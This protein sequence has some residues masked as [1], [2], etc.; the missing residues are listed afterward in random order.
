[1]HAR[2]LHR[3]SECTSGRFPLFLASRRPLSR[4]FVRAYTCA[5]IIA[6]RWMHC[7]LCLRGFAQISGS[8]SW[9]WTRADPTPDT[10][11]THRFERGVLVFCRAGAGAVS[12]LPFLSD[13]HSH[14]LFVKT[15]L[16]RSC[17]LALFWSAL[18]QWF[19]VFFFFRWEIPTDPSPLCVRSLRRKSNNKKRAK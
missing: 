18:L 11:H 12:L 2:C 7:L 17:C 5:T 1:M 8:P 15:I 4:R 16:L 6:L 14:T 13:L 9:W 19:W 3:S 10:A